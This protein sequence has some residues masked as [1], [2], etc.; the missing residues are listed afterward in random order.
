VRRWR[1]RK[2][3]AGTC[4]RPSIHIGDDAVDRSSYDDIEQ[5]T[6]HDHAAHDHH[7]LLDDVDHDFH[8]AADDNDTTDDD[9][10]AHDNDYGADRDDARC[11]VADDGSDRSSRDR[12][13]VD[14]SGR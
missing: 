8:D 13:G 11:A 7:G 4:V 9:H 2:R 1:R 6:F 3:R 12:A 5:R 14:E 10:T